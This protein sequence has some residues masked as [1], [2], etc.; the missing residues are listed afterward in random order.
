MFTLLL[1]SNLFI[2][3]PFKQMKITMASNSS[4]EEHQKQKLGIRCHC[5][6][7]LLPGFI[8]GFS[9]PKYQKSIQTVSVSLL[10]DYDEKNRLLYSLLLFPGI[11][12]QKKSHSVACVH[13]KHIRHVKITRYVFVTRMHANNVF[14]RIVQ[15]GEKNPYRV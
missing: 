6:N 2:K 12:H 14:L 13:M 3:R 9:K 10:R 4:F 11:S 1:F 8:V 5:K 15:G 7:N